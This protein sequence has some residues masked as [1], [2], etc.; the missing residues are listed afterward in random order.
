MQRDDHTARCFTTRPRLH[1]K[2]AQATSPYPFLPLL[3]SAS[4]HHAHGTLRPGQSVQAG[5]NCR[6]RSSRTSRRP[7][8]RLMPMD[9]L[10]CC[11]GLG[12]V[13]ERATRRELWLETYSC[14]TELVSSRVR[15]SIPPSAQRTSETHFSPLRVLLV[16]RRRLTLL[17]HRC[18]V[19]RALSRVRTVREGTASEH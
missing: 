12:S 7:L 8:G 10:Q 9:P 13:F 15:S 19:L 18:S 1:P 17:A 2:P 6:R 3:R 14:E 16:L 4:S 5:S 11:A